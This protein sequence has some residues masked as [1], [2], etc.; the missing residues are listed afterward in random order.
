MKF[1]IKLCI[2]KISKFIQALT[3]SGFVIHPTESKFLPSKTIEYYL[4]FIID[5]EKTILSLTKGKELDIKQLCTDLNQKNEDKIKNLTKLLGKISGSL[6]SE[7]MEDFNI[8]Q[9]K[10]QKLR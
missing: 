3:A 9:W 4:S 8:E 10:C 1:S 7:H 5:F 2:Y 6:I